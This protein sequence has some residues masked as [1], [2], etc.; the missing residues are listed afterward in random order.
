[1]REG[2]LVLQNNKNEYGGS[3]AQLHSILTSIF[4]TSQCS[5]QF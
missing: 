2:T 3:E 5:Q 1:M 4:D